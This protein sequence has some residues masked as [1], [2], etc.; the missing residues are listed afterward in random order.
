[1][2]RFIEPNVR[3]KWH[4]VGVGWTLDDRQQRAK[5]FN[6]RSLPPSHPLETS[7]TPGRTCLPCIYCVPPTRLNDG[8]RSSPRMSVTVVWWSD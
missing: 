3:F 2:K 1:M 7:R 4:S 6:G 5:P 8:R